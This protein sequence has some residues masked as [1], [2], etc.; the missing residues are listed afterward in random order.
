MKK[1]AI[2][3]LCA[4]FTFSCSSKQKSKSSFKLFI[5]SL[6]A[7]VDG[8]AFVSAYETNTNIYSIYKLDSAQSTSIPYGTY[9]L[10]FVTFA[11][12]VIKSGEMMCGSL[13]NTTF[14]SQDISLNIN[15]NANECSL[16]KYSTTLLSLKKSIV[17]IWETDK[18]DLSHWGQ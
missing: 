10:L 2:I 5:G 15:I 17:S 12:P 16:P 3:L 9:N 18:W 7:P 1:I 8:G 4:F 13:D 6:A 14:N 11:G